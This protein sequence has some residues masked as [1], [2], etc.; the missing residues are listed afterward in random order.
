[1]D[2]K[3]MIAERESFFGPIISSYSRAQAIEDGTLIEADPELCKELKII[4]P[5]AISAG[6]WKY[7]DPEYIA[8]MP[9]QS[10]TGRLWDLLSLFVLYAKKNRGD[11]FKYRCIFQVK[12]FIG[13]KFGYGPEYVT[14]IARCGPGDA[15]EPVITLML[16]ED[17]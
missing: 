3:K 4:Y 7:V 15:G 17:D 11:F 10:V 13:Y 8:D 6:L 9:G 5:V 1:M 12:T 2:G 14:I 16:P